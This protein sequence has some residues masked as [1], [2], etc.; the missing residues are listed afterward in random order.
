MHI[1]SEPEISI[2]AD[3]LQSHSFCDVDDAKIYVK[4]FAQ[5]ERV[6][7]VWPPTAEMLYAGE[8]I[9]I[10]QDLDRIASRLGSPRPRTLPLTEAVPLHDGW[11]AKREHSHGMRHVILPSP[12]TKQRIGRGAK[13]WFQ[14]QFAPLLVQLGEWRAIFVHCQHMITIHARPT[15]DSGWTGGPQHDQWSLADLR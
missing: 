11:V 13:R 12:G 10:V 4:A 14:Q 9:K 5:L 3:S 15:G 7:P 8:K 2:E 1:I 6:I